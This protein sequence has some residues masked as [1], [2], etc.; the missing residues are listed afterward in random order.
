MSSS[1]KDNGEGGMTDNS[2]TVRPTK[3]ALRAEREAR[4]SQALRDNLA[5]RKAQVRA[6]NEKV[7]AP[8]STDKATPQGE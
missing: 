4:L 2:A 8:Q 6:R 1:D 3:K 7:P 5:R